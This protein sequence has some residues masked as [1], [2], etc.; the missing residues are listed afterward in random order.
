MTVPRYSTFNK[1]AITIP[2]YHLLKSGF[3]IYSINITHPTALIV[4]NIKQ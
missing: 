2:A 1:R 3:T 4:Q